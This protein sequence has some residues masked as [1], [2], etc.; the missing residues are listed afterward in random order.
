V[1]LAGRRGAGGAGAVERF[2]SRRDAAVV[3]ATAVALFAFIW[4]L[5]Y[6]SF[7]TYWQ[8]AFWDSFKAFDVWS[9]TGMSEFHEKP[10]YTYVMW[11]LQEESPIL[12]LACAGA[13]AA[14]A[15]R[16]KNRFA[17]FASAWAFGLLAAYSLI[18]YKTPWLVLSF[19]VPMCVA[20]G[21][22]VQS[23]ARRG[24]ARLAA[25]LVPLAL[26][27]SVCLF[28]TVMVNFINYDDDRYPYVYSHTVRSA[29][30]MVRE[31]ERAS[32]RSGAKEPGVTIVSAEYWPLPWYFRDNQSVGYAGGTVYSSYDPQTTPV[33]IAR[34]SDSATEDTYRK[35]LPLLSGGYAEVGTYE[36]RP[37]VELVVF[38]RR[39]IAGK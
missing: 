25:A 19:V 23:L 5:F 3:A 37:S 27:V 33:V 31:V 28:Q 15:E 20:G 16:R 26:A 9:K 36:L 1:R 2:T 39:D 32:A 12:L 35:L 17:I 10:S 38:E 7:F 24:R 29:V 6:S 18:K 21:Y 11:L 34:K 8:G 14:L 13:L 4:V 30:E 22:A